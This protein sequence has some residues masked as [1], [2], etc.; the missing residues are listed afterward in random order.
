MGYT[1]RLSKGSALT[2]TEAD[3]NFKSAAYVVPVWNANFQYSPGNFTTVGGDIYKALTSNLNKNPPTNALDWQLWV[4]S[5]T[6]DITGIAPAVINENDMVSNSAT[7]VPT[8]RSVKAYVDT[9]AGLGYNDTKAIIAVSGSLISN[10]DLTWSYNGVMKKITGI[11]TNGAITSVKLNVNNSPAAGMVLGYNAASPSGLSW[12]SAANP[13]NLIV[14]FATDPLLYTAPS[15]LSEVCIGIGDAVVIDAGN[16]NCI[17]IGDQAEILAGSTTSDNCAIFGGTLSSIVGSIGSTVLGSTDS[18]IGQTNV[19]SLV[20]GGQNNTTAASIT[21][22]ALLASSD[23]TVTANQGTVIAG[24]N[25]E[26]AAV[27]STVIGSYAKSTL[28]LSLVFAADG[29]NNSGI[30]AGSAQEILLTS[31]LATTTDATTVSLELNGNP[32]PVDTDG[33]WAFSIQVCA[34]QVDGTAGTDGDSGAFFIT[35]AVKNLAGTS[36]FLGT[37]AVTSYLDAGASAWTAGVSVTGA[38]LDIRVTGETDKTI[39]W[40]ASMRVTSLGAADIL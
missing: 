4:P 26:A 12:V 15:V 18:A 39:R 34:V 37:A 17:A 2:F 35:G 22:G 25:S 9:F 19:R 28:P 7:R 30:V 40:T 31:L 1:F 6:H 29:F 32:L 13:F 16:T 21:E 5:H 10:A 23:S 8:Q 24:H 14:E 38:N 3:D 11:I 20:V 36:S 33:V 27:S